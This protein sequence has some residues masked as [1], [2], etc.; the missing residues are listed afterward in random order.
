[1]RL[2]DRENNSKRTDT[3]NNLRYVACLKFKLLCGKRNWLFMGI[4][5]TH[6]LREAMHLRS[7]TRERHFIRYSRNILDVVDRIKNSYADSV[8]RKSFQSVDF[9]PSY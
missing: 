4:E 7:D 6:F 8:Y 5:R 2:A 1:M 9:R 3:F